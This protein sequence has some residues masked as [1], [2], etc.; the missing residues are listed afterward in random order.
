ME[1][2]MNKSKRQA[3]AKRKAK[4][5]RLKRWNGVPHT[6]LQ[7]CDGRSAVMARAC[8]GSFLK[9]ANMNNDVVDYLKSKEDCEEYLVATL[10][11]ALRETARLDKS[12][13]AEV[14]ERSVTV[15]LRA[16]GRALD[17]GL[18]DVAGAIP[19]CRLREVIPEE[20]MMAAFAA[21]FRNERLRAFIAELFGTVGGEHG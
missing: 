10:L 3:R 11:Y 15:T 1:A 14:I 9:G 4:T 5:Q 7:A 13:A 6:P 8:G 20:V 2:M 19:S 16:I 12:E 18:R 21:E 17:L